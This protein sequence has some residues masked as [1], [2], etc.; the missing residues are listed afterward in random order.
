VVS[1]YKPYASINFFSERKASKKLKE[2]GF[3]LYEVTL[4]YG[5]VFSE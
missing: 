2:I 4:L 3:D 1:G 5:I